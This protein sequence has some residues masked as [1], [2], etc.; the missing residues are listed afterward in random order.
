[1]P[2]VVDI[3]N[4]LPPVVSCINEFQR[5]AETENPELNL[6]WEAYEKLLNDQFVHTATESGI[7]RWES[8]LGI[9]P[10]SATLEERRWEILNRLNVKIPYTMTMLKNKFI[11]MFGEDNFTLQLISDTYTLKVRINDV[12]KIESTSSML[13]VIVPA[14]LYVD[15]G[16]M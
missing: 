14:N 15:L 6:L 5:L 8:I 12:K 2:R 3:I 16:V 13:D 9:N 1:M 10:G 4:Y 7:R 11:S